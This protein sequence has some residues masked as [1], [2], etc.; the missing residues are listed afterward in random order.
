[1]P[2]NYQRFLLENLDFLT[3][4]VEPVTDEN[5]II[6]DMPG[7]IELYTHVPVVP[8]LVSHFR[9]ALNVN[10]C[11]TYLLESTFV[12]DRAKFFAGTLSAMSAMVMLELPHINVMSKVDLIKNTVG[13]RELR[14]F[15]DPDASLLD[16]ELSQSEYHATP[17]ASNRKTPLTAA[18]LMEG[19]SFYRLNRAVAK[20]IDDFSMVSFLKLDVQ[21]EDSVG[22]ILSYIDD[23]I[24]Y[25]EGQEPK[26]PNDEINYDYTDMEM[27]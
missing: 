27:G 13:K 20:M 16:E 21:K 11:A 7:Q 1:M 22:A 24:Q 23:A 6:I 26:E 8:A 9:T 12:I 15:I 17:E 18:S 5:L 3:E 19:K 2:N 25:H 14:R 4:L 10:L